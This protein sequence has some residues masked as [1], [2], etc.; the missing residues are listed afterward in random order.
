MIKLILN[1]FFSR[2]KKRKATH[3]NRLVE[4]KKRKDNEKIIGI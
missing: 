3:S 4:M 1:L 2:K